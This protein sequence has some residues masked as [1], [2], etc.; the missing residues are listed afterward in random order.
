[1]LIHHHGIDR[2]SFFRISQIICWV[3]NC[4][5]VCI[6]LLRQ[7]TN[8]Y[9]KQSTIFFH[10][11]LAFVDNLLASVFDNSFV[12]LYTCYIEK[13]DLF[14]LFHLY[15]HCADYKKKGSWNKIKVIKTRKLWTISANFLTLSGSCLIILTHMRIYWLLHNMKWAFN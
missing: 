11:R 14:V 4:H 9:L 13:R 5:Y 6:L 8:C 7:N 15:N 3:G 12:V 2:V 1:M 10:P